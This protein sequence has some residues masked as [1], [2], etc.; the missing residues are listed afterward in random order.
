MLHRAIWYHKGDRKL[1]NIN[2]FNFVSQCCGKAQVAS[3]DRL[4]RYLKLFDAALIRMLLADRECIGGRRIAFL[5]ETS[6]PSRPARRRTRALHP[7]REDS[8]H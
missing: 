1:L 2:D 7:V 8:C 5:L 3:S 4:Q 6:S